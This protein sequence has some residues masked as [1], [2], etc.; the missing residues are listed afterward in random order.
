MF[1]SVF[2]PYVYAR[3]TLKEYEPTF[4]EQCTTDIYI[5]LYNMKK[6]A[7]RLTSVGLADARPNN[8]SGH[9]CVKLDPPIRSRNWIS[10]VR[11]DHL[12]QT[13][14]FI[15]WS[16]SNAVSSWSSV[17]SLVL[18]IVK[19]LLMDILYSGYLV[20]SDKNLLSGLIES[21]LPII[22]GSPKCRHVQILIGRH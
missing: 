17:L 6:S 10:W 12:L 20:K 22:Y 19:L 21:A 11:L 8:L 15:F 3:G 7:I 2:C 1:F 16:N 18:A 13:R 9:D 4:T 5:H 14:I